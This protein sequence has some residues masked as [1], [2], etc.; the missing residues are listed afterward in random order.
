[1]ERAQGADRPWWVLL[2]SRPRGHPGNLLTRLEGK[3]P[4]PLSWGLISLSEWLTALLLLSQGVW[5][6]KPYE[7][8]WALGSPIHRA[9]PSQRTS[10][11]VHPCPSQTAE[12]LLPRNKG[13][14]L[15]TTSQ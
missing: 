9:V 8:P 4:L 14:Q 15:N 12:P 13:K 5:G 10:L 6:G 11:P 1:M 3:G 7:I 2:G